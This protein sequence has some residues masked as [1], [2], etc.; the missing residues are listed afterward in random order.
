MIRKLVLFFFLSLMF[1]AS[2]LQAANRYVRQ[3]ASGSANGTDW[4]NAYTT[5]PS[6]LTRGDTYYIADGGYGG[7]T[8]DDLVSGATII[9]IKKATVADHGTATGWNNAYGDGQAVWTSWEFGSDY[10]VMDGQSGGGPGQW[11]TGFGLAVRNLSLHLIVA[12]G[13][14]SNI[15][16]KHTEVDGTSNACANRDAFYS[17]SGLSDL[18]VQYSYFHDIGSDVFQL[19]GNMPRF[20]FEYS[21]MARNNDCSTDHG[22]GFEYGAGT[23]SN[24]VHRYNWFEDIITTYLWGAHTGTLES[25]EIYGNIVTGGGHNNGLVSGLSSGGTISNLKFYNN[26][27]I[28]CNLKLNCG[29][30]H[31]G[32]GI[33]N[34]LRNNIWFNSKGGRSNNRDFGW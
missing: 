13:S 33:N 16:I 10:W 27:I 29:L 6:T 9:M 25:A 11:E 8:F 26:S 4:T 3:G 22:D 7:Y 24:W 30:R 14:R 21:K 28:N 18:T 34:D 2:P 5:L 1:G 15:T 17:I 20:T 31:T 23:A 12:S 32:G 19:R